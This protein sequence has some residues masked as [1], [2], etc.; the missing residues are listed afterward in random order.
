GEAFGARSRKKSKRLFCGEAYRPVAA[1]STSEIPGKALR[2]VLAALPNDVFRLRKCGRAID[3]LAGTRQPEVA[4]VAAASALSPLDRDQ[5]SG[6]RNIEFLGCFLDRRV[7]LARRDGS[8]QF[9]GRML[10]QIDV[11][12]RRRWRRWLL[13]RSQIPLGRTSGAAARTP[14]ITV[15]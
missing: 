11:P 2:P 9:R 10:G 8:Y 5:P 3:R 1:A 13:R 7:D 6:V 15:E 4:P 14:A 12:V